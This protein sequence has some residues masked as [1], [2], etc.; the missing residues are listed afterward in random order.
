MA[1]NLL[2]SARAIVGFLNQAEAAQDDLNT[3][4]SNCDAAAE[5]LLA[6][7][8]GPAAEAFR[9]EEEEFKMWG[10]QMDSKTREIFGIIGKILDGFIEADSMGK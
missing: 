1:L 5:N 8:Q 2:V 6:N 10:R 7:W 3:A 9:K 4:M